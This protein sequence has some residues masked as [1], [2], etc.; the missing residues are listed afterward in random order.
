MA[1]DIHILSPHPEFQIERDNSVLT[2]TSTEGRQTERQTHRQTDI[3]YNAL[4]R[5]PETSKPKEPSNSRNQ[6]FA[7]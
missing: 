4:F 5:T 7:P 6:L 1:G 2:L 3:F